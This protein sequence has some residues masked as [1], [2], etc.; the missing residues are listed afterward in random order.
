MHN[1]DYQNQLEQV[2]FSKQDY[3]LDCFIVHKI[4]GTWR[5]QFEEQKSSLETL[6]N[7]FSEVCWITIRH[8]LYFDS[9]PMINYV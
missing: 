2:Q 4:N 8:I 1:T 5:Y 3:N 7:Y 6:E 9:G